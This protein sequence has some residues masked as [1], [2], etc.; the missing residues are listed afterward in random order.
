MPTRAWASRPFASR[1]PARQP[2]SVGSVFLRHRHARDT[3]GFYL[4]AF[5]A[6]VGAL[7]VLA[8][9]GKPLIAAILGLSS[10]RAVVSG[11]YQ[12][13]SAQGLDY[14]S[15]YIAAAIAAAAWYAGTALVL[16]DLRQAAV[17]PV[18]RRGAG[19]QAMTGDLAWQLG[20]SEGDAGVRAQL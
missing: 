8:A 14:A 12:F 17:L 20:R 3:L 19:K 5:A 10:A 13:S 4:L 16:E 11:I 7:G 9:S 18:F 15:G 6:A 2:T 1:P